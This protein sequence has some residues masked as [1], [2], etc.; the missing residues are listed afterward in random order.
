LDAVNVV[1]RYTEAV[2]VFLDTAKYRLPAKQIWQDKPVWV[3]GSKNAPQT[4]TAMM[5]VDESESAYDNALSMKQKVG[6]L[7]T[8]EMTR[9]TKNTNLTGGG[10]AKKGDYFSV[11][12]TGD[13][14]NTIVGNSREN[15]LAMT[16]GVLLKDADYLAIY[17]DND[18]F[19]E[20]DVVKL[21]DEIIANHP[22][23]SVEIFYGGQT[24]YPLIMT[25]E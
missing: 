24:A 1:S 5:A 4:I 21:Q 17:Y 7:R 3:I 10:M 15:V 12:T 14:S 13:S 25:A 19:N 22:Y 11:I 20:S 16:L 9:A 8:S 23:L 6:E 18:K 2:F